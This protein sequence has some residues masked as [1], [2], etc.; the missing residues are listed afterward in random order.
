M[1]ARDLSSQTRH[2]SQATWPS[3]VTG[4]GVVLEHRLTCPPT[5]QLPFFPRYCPPRRSEPWEG[6]TDISR[7]A[8]RDYSRGTQ[9]LYVLNPAHVPL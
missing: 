7:S 9:S 3:V 8:P 2:P 5:H 4:N 1:D 6:S